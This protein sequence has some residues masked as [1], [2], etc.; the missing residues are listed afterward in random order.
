MGTTLLKI[1]IHA[2]SLFIM[3][4]GFQGLGTLGM[5]EFIKDQKGGHFQ[6]LTI[7]GLV[8][9]AAAMASSLAL[10]LA[11]SLGGLRTAK[12]LF[13]MIS[14]PLTFVI[15]SIYWTLILMFPTLIVW[16]APPESSSIPTEIPPEWRIPLSMDLSLHAV[17]LIAVAL[18]FI[19]FET[20]YSKKEQLIVAPI[21]TIAYSVFYGVWVEYCATFNGRFPY[22]F[23][24]DNPFD[25]RLKIY[26]AVTVI[27]LGAF[28]GLNKIHGRRPLLL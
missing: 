20:K 10:D 24:T 7:Q 3:V 2:G 6:F 17:P 1:A 26:A 25:I 14:L 15:S 11:P 13:L 12:R 5:H 19:L 21:M 8:L 23:L 18:D 9:A 28:W 27:A 22:P 4:R 16:A